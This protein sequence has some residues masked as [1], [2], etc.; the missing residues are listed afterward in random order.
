[1]SEALQC[2]KTTDGKPCGGTLIVDEAAGTVTHQMTTPNADNVQMRNLQ[3]ISLEIIHNEEIT[4]LRH[5]TVGGILE[6]MTGER[7]CNPH[8][9]AMLESV[10][11]TAFSL[12]IRVGIEMERA[13]FTPSE[14]L[15]GGERL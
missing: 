10:F 12:G 5:H 8:L 13:E 11:S 15:A 1:M 6:T 9:G 4:C 3:D 14:S 7:R 2:L